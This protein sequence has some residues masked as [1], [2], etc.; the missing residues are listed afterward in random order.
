M[1]CGDCGTWEDPAIDWD[2]EVI[3][4]ADIWLRRVDVPVP[5]VGPRLDLTGLDMVWWGALDLRDAR[6]LP[7]VGRITTETLGEPVEGPSAG[8]LAG[9]LLLSLVW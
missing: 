2:S 4:E 1:G 5:A 3:D 8:I 7:L 9:K 6:P